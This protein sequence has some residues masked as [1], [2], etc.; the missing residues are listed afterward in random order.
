MI[1][2]I[3]ILITGRYLNSNVSCNCGTILCLHLEKYF[4]ELIEATS[5][6]IKV[7]TGFVYHYA[8][9]KYTML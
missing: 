4:K 9:S 6:S 8:H 2:N 5:S 1:C 3:Y 7:V